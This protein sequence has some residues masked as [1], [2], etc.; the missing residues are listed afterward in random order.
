IEWV[1]SYVADRKAARTKPFIDAMRELAKDASDYI[2]ACD[3]D[4]E[5]SVIAY[6]ILK[7]LCG[8]EA[9]E[10][11]KR[12]KFS[13][14]TAEELRRAYENLMPKLDFEMIDAGLTRHTIDWYWGMNVSRAMSAA[15]EA[16]GRKFTKLSA[17]RVQTPTLKIL[18]D[19]EKEIQAFKP[20]PYWL[21]RLILHIG[22]SDF[23]AE[24]STE[25]FWSRGEAEKVVAA[26]KGKRAIVKKIEART[27]QRMPPHP[28]DLGSLQSEAYRCFGY[29]PM[30]T[31]QIAQDLYLAGAISYP[32]TSSQ[33][34]PPSIGYAAVIEKLGEIST[35]YREIANELLKMP[36]LVPREGPKTD[37]AHPSIYPTGEKVEGLKGPHAKIYDLIVR[38]FFSVFGKPAV[39]RGERADIDVGG[40]LFHLHGRRIVDEG[41]LKYYGKYGGTEEK[42]LPGM[43]EGQEIE[44]KDV[45]L[46][47]KETQPPPR[48]NPA[49][50]V[51]KMEERNL[52]T[53]ATRGEI[54]Q[55][56]YS[57]NYISGSQISVTELGMEVVNTLEKYCPE[58]VSEELTAR[59]ETE[60]ER[61]QEGKIEGKEIIAKARLELD[62][63]L[64]K[65]KNKQMDIGR[66]LAQAVSL[67]IAKQYVLGRCQACGGELRILRSKKTHKRFA[68]CANYPECRQAFPLPQRGA[69]IPLGKNCEKCGAPVIQVSSP[70]RRPYRMCLDP[71]CETKASWK[72]QSDNFNSA[73]PVEN[74]RKQA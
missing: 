14:L 19:R 63:I 17:G 70:G 49:S 24:H 69:I 41:W 32:R 27:Y 15:V 6:N 73:N 20:T 30:R 36:A 71:S 50:L 13:T 74:R 25:R 58:I 38:R 18:A 47:E 10:K 1:P 5:G 64:E 4:I 40:Q 65:F 43:K 22:T 3:F 54:V 42:V 31:Q 34:L 37:P 16:V 21:V 2:N 9:V 33:K 48:Y 55:T 52:G 61:I 53:K 62:R 23:E 67:A 44:V 45:V 57:R 60:M 39:I 28:F 51:K 46:E 12:M 72:K 26:C 68:G 56:L 11:A 7:N 59:L 66:D 8:E 35:Q 29:T